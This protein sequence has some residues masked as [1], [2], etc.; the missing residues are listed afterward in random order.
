MDQAI[1]LV[2][3]NSEFYIFTDKWFK[4]KPTKVAPTIISVKLHSDGVR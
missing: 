3:M 2:L 4:G 1:L